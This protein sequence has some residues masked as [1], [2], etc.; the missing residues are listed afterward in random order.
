MPSL[1]TDS[2]LSRR[3]VRAFFDF[4]DSV[5]PAP[6]ADL[7]GLDVARECLREVF[8]LPLTSPSNDDASLKPALLLDLFRSLDANVD[9]HT[10]TAAADADVS[11]S[12]APKA[13]SNDRVGTSYEMAGESKDELFGQF[14]AALEKNHFFKTAPD[15]NDDPVQLD[16]ATH[17]FHDALNVME[18]AG[19]QS[20]TK[21]SLAETLKAQGNQAMQSKRYS[22]AVE[23]YSCA[24]SL[25]ENNAVYY[26]NRAAAFTQVHKYTEAISDCLKSIEIDPHYSKAYS[27]LGLAYYALGNYRDAIDRGFR[28]ALALDPDNESVKENIRVAEQKLKEHQGN[29]SDQM[30]SSGNAW[31]EIPNGGIHLSD[32]LSILR[33]MVSQSTGEQPHPQERQGN[34]DLGEN[35]P[36]EL[37]GALQSLMGGFSGAAAATNGNPQPQDSNGRPPTN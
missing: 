4:L 27:R 37:R 33:N 6:G 31:Q 26:C 28:K 10:S 12:Q 15:G 13:Q 14:F 24:I 25:Y 9:D 1:K 5:E 22:E 23:L 16:K 30:N 36:P 2:P 19:C 7:E 21:S 34:A 17:L 35:L 8:K 11:H 18:Q 29:G 20:F 32:F 3:I